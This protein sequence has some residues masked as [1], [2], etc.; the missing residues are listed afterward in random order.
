MHCMCETVRV[1]VLYKDSDS[2]D[3]QIP[4]RLEELTVLYVFVRASPRLTHLV[5]ILSDPS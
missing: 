3:A 1:F 5:Q 2:R 4:T